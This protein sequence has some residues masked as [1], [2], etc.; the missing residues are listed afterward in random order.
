MSNSSSLGQKVR[1]EMT[2]YLAIST[3]LF[4]CFSILILFEDSL[5]QKT[6]GTLLP[7]SVA[8]VKAL[9]IGKFILIGKAIG[10]GE[11]RSP[12]VLVHRIFWKSA[13][14]LGALMLFVSIEEVVV[15]LAHGRE[16]SQVAAEFL[17]RPLME[18][19]AP[20][21]LMFLVLLPLIA[22]EELDRA[23]G[24]GVIRHLLFAENS[25]E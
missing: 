20:S 14:T 1:S 4:I 8:V 16:V 21:A 9:V 5:L 17:A 19:V 24:D 10:V 22:F 11:R 2:A 3:Y 23:L 7:L 25:E 13:A 12:R 18:K 15:G 6:G